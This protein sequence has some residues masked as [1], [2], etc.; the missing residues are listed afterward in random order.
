MGCLPEPA[1]QRAFLLALE[2]DNAAEQ[3]MWHVV[4]L[5]N[6]NVWMSKMMAKIE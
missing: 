1:R 2:L 4:Q 6:P 5:A 3:G